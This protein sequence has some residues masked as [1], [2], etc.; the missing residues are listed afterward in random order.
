MQKV[1]LL[2]QSEHLCR[3][4]D[5]REKPAH[6]CPQGGPRG[7]GG[8]LACDVGHC[9]RGRPALSF[10]DWLSLSLLSHYYTIG[11]SLCF[12]GLVM[13]ASPYTVRSLSVVL[14]KR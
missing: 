12:R 6:G 7:G 8:G 4:G 5:G 14:I 11:N 1:P 9:G 10:T 2:L 13:N 3:H